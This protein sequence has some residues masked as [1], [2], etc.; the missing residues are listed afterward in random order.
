MIDR[1][2]DT[3]IKQIFSDENRIAYWIRI[4]LEAMKA[5]GHDPG[6]TVPPTMEAIQSYEKATKHDV[7]AF[8]HAWSAANPDN[9]ELQQWMHFGLTSSNVVDCALALQL[10][11][12]HG[13]LNSHLIQL[14]QRV[15]LFAE[16]MER[17]T[18]IG[19]THGQY[20][21]PRSA[22]TPW[23]MHR[24]VLVRMRQR[25]GAHF[26]NIGLGSLAGPAGDGGLDREV[27][28]RA[29]RSLGLRGTVDSTQL[30]PR[31]G[32]ASWAQMMALL[33]TEC[34]AIATHVWLLT[35]SGVGE[36]YTDMELLQVGSSAMP[37]KNNPILAENIRGL[38]RMARSMVEPLVLGMVQW[39]DHDLAHSSVE[40]V[41]IPDICHL[42]ATI[43]RR[44]F[45]LVDTVRWNEYNAEF[46][47]GQAV[48][49][50]STTHNELLNKVV[51]GGNYLDEH[52]NIRE[53]IRK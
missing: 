33:A 44:T 36:M 9:A 13:Y 34:E 49:M 38:A 17:Y 1:Y 27:E 48:V 47:L 37:H 51:A 42:T 8:L 5:Q 46:N 19:R 12:A 23:L 11:E 26:A 41:Y 39:G 52:A 10:L 28:Y 21:I 30:I 53:R 32:L 4:E 50:G 7:V 22:G 31:D 2:E 20:S 40:R 14:T 16:E 6:D 45:R 18:Q 3:A 29:I 43:L 24:G 25:M 35:Q 15:A